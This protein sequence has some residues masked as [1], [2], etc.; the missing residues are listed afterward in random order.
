MNVLHDTAVASSGVAGGVIVVHP[1]SFAIIYTSKTF[2]FFDSHAHDDQ[3][4]LF[5]KVPIESAG[6]YLEYF[7]SVHYHSRINFNE[8]SGAQHVAHFTMLDLR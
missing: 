4:A 5:S 2:P 1:F 6:K 7:F 8:R 3:G